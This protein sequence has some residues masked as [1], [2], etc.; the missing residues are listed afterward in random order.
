MVQLNLIK[1]LEDD[2]AG[3][4]FEWMGVRKELHTFLD[5][6]AGGEISDQLTYINNMLVEMYQMNP[7]RVRTFDLLNYESDEEQNA[8]ETQGIP[9]R[10]QKARPAEEI[11][12]PDMR[13][14][15][16]K[17]RMQS[18]GMASGD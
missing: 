15:R 1:K 10:A 8:S 7:T 9:P 18:L 2:E 13:E 5:N 16:D 17:E 12:M 6:K 11:A 14:V 3:M 4:P